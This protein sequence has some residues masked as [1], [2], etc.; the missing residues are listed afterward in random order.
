M[1]L[2]KQ[3]LKRNSKDYLFATDKG[4]YKTNYSYTVEN[5]IQKFSV[6]DAIEVYQ[7]MIEYINYYYT[8]WY[9]THISQYHKDGSNTDLLNNGYIDVN[10]EDISESWQSHQMCSDYIATEND[11]VFEIED[12]TNDDGDIQAYSS[13]AN[14]TLS[15]LALDDIPLSYILKRWKSGMCELYVYLTTTNTY[16]LPFNEGVPNCKV[17]QDEKVVRYS[18]YGIDTVNTED[19]A[20]TSKIGDHYTNIQLN[21]MSSYCFMD[22]IQDIQINGNSLPL[23]I[24]KDRDGLVDQA[25][26]NLYQSFIE[27]SVVDSCDISKTDEN[28][29]YN[30]RFRCFGSDA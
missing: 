9:N 12:A 26:Q 2:I 27:P 24:Y 23:N 13:N 30:F 25:S 11:I 17:D 15:G 10:F 4:L 6:Q 3:V 7:S 18:L 22:C 28:G 29:C 16:Y 1:S 19:R 20:Q 21:I 14:Q 8:T 5:D